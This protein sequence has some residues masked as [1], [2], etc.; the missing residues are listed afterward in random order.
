MK[1]A[2]KNQWY[3]KLAVDDRLKANTMIRQLVKAGLSYEVAFDS[4]KLHFQG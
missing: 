3:R 2:R 1:K 4:V